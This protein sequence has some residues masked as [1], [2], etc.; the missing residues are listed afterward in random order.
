MRQII[1]GNW[2]MFGKRADIELF[3]A[4]LRADA[5]A[6]VDMLVCPPFTLLDRFA[7]SLADSKI[8]LGGQDCHPAPEGAHTGDISAAM[9]LSLIHI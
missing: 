5:P 3:T 2:K 6:H 4:S 7:G 1:A 9:I 8:A